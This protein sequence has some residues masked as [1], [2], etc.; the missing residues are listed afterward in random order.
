VDISCKH[1]TSGQN[2]YQPQSSAAGKKRRR[3]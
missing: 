2:A 3:A 1:A